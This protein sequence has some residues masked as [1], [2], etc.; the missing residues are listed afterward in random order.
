MKKVMG[1]E[2]VSKVFPE[3]TIS[4]FNQEQFPAVISP[5]K[6]T[7]KKEELLLLLKQENKFFKQLMLKTGALLFRGFPLSD[8]DDFA[9]VIEGL[10]TGDCIDYIGGDSPRKKIKRNV[11]TSTEAPPSI[12]IPLHNEL[13][14]VKNYPSHI[15]FFCE[16][17]TDAHGETIIGDC[18]KIY[19]AMDP[20]VMSRFVEKGIKYVSRYYYKS[21]LNSRAHKTW[22]NV[23]ETED[24]EEVERKCHENEFEF[25]WNK[26]DWIEVSQKRPAV[27]N[28]PKT[29]EKVWF[30]Q[31]HLYD[32]NPKFL[33]WFYYLA[34][35]IVYFQK[36]TKLHDVY[37]GDGTPIPRADIYHVMDVL[38]ANTVYFPWKKGDVLALDNVLAMHGRSTF[39]GKRRILAAMTRDMA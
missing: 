19:Q 37:F 32:L 29:N 16:I 24:K 18:R 15:Y 8:V 39:A 10:G 27:M 31:V 5:K 25:K 23:F 2:I 28:H 7:M 11:Y 14:F 21:K 17:P 36:H 13:S 4:S 33:G 30:N 38:D 35:K 6:P 34:T 26:N 12:K 20:Q 9:D 3:I 1:E 22:I